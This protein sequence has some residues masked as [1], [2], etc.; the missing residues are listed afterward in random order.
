M[1]RNWPNSLS[2][3]AWDLNAMDYLL[4][5]SLGPIQ[6]FIRVRTALP[7][8]GDPSH[9]RERGPGYASEVFLLR[10]RPS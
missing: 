10:R 2:G 5:V 6:D 1:T 7:G 3:A 9:L 8:H 4:L